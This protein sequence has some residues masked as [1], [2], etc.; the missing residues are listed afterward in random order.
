MRAPGVFY[1]ATHVMVFVIVILVLG[2]GAY[3]AVLTL[4]S[5]MGSSSVIQMVD[6]LRAQP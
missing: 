2:F 5:P 4:S 3:A 1:R 6:G